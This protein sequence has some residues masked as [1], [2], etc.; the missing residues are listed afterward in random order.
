M[1]HQEID[2]EHPSIRPSTPST[3]TV[4]P[5]SI[6]VTSFSSSSYVYFRLSSSLYKNPASPLL[7]FWK[8]QDDDNVFFAA[9]AVVV[10][11]FAGSSIKSKNKFSSIFFYF[12][13]LYGALCGGFWWRSGKEGVHLAKCIEYALFV[14]HRP[15]HS[16]RTPYNILISWSN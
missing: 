11:P 5:P 10:I 3:G 15:P 2:D 6:A 14:L 9:V 1:P 16:G 13:F 12:R 8:P 4:F 7:D